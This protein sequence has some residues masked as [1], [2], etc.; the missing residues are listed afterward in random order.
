MVPFIVFT[1]PRSRSAWLSH[2]LSSDDVQVGHDLILEC[3]YVSD[4]FRLLDARGGTIETGA[5]TGA[6]VIR[7]MRP[8]IKM[9]VVRRPVDQ[10]IRS[11]VGIGLANL[12][13][14]QIEQRAELL[15]ELSKEPGVL[16]IAFEDLAT[17]DACNRLTEF[18]RGAPCPPER[19]DRFADFNIQ[20]NIPRRVAKLQAKAVNIQ[21]IREQV[22]ELQRGYAGTC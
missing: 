17:Y 12:V 1:L 10:V 15:D 6:K 7:R 2:F 9:A 21:R 5:I 14:R 16:T 22:E 4:F 20:L 11:L 13:P 8:D 3:A 19:W 18:C